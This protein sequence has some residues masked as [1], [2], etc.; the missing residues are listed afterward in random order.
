MELVPPC[1]PE[2]SP[3]VRITRSRC[4]TSCSSSKRA[5]SALYAVHEFDDKGGRRVALR[6]DGTAPVA[7]AFVEHRPVTPW[8][9]YTEPH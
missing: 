7:R 9:T 3:L 8:N 2:C 1:T 5:N 6:P 4:C